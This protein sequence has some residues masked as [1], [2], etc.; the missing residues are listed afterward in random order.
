MF[1]ALCDLRFNGTREYMSEI[2]E[3]F[4]AARQPSDRR[5]AEKVGSDYWNEDD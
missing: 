2:I 5:S 4:V 3:S 1:P